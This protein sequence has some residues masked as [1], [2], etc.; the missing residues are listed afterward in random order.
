M[1]WAV[2]YCV[3]LGRE[4]GVE[5]HAGLRAWSEQHFPL[6]SARPSWVEQWRGLLPDERIAELAARH[7]SSTGH[8][9]LCDFHGFVQTRSLARYRKVMGALQELERLLPFARILVSDDHYTQ[10]NRPSEV[11][12]ANPVELPPG[13]PLTAPAPAASAER[14][15]AAASKQAPEEAETDEVDE[16]LDRAR[17]DFERFKRGSS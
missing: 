14:A 6:K 11:D 9:G 2:T 12:L 10:R 7:S 4:L 1:G 15:V 16:L 17:R 3:T 13:P 5:E 8:P